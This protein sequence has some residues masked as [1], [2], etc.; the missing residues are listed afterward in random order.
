MT[1]KT[2]TNLIESSADEVNQYLTTNTGQRMFEESELVKIKLIA[3]GWGSSGYYPSAVL[4]RDG[5]AAWPA[6]THMY[7]NHRSDG[8]RLERDIRNL[9][10]VTIDTPQYIENGER[11]AGLYATAE[12]F[13]THAPF[14][15][16]RSKQIGLSIVGSGEVE[17]GEAEGRRG[18]IIT[19][20][21]HTGLNSVDFV[22]KAGAGGLIVESDSGNNNI[23][24]VVNIGDTNMKETTD[25]DNARLMA[26]NAELKLQLNAM[27]QA[28][29][30]TEARQ[31]VR[32]ALKDYGL[33]ESINALILAASTA[34]LPFNE[35][36]KLD[37]VK[38]SETV[39]THAEAIKQDAPV[40]NSMAGFGQSEPTPP[41][42]LQETINE[43]VALLVADGL[44]EAEAKMA[45]GGY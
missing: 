39:T 24:E 17:E 32:N 40:V 18:N 13:D 29:T 37:A 38:L 5:A 16:E 25:A 45:V 23:V 15:K 22:T 6:G 21:H 30:V 12:V 3:P 44:T 27:R 43:S 4:E 36:G 8:E 31:L 9:A 19:S 7:L 41:Q 20:L 10:A 11:G 34:N 2:Y 26:E 14:I 28:M 35:A 1:I 42:S 33:T